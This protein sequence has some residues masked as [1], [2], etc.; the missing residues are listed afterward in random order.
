M[1]KP[2]LRTLKPRLTPANLS[3]VATLNP[4]SWRTKDMSS[5]ARGYGYAWQQAREQHL[6]QHPLCVMCDAKGRT[7]RATVVDHKT[8]H[9]G[10][11]VLFWDRANWQSLCAPCHDGEKKRQEAAEAARGAS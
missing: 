5:T 2:R 11:K 1:S 6:R 4:G 9:R 8:P 10:D 7:T 3:P